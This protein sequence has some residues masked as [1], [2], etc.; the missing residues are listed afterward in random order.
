MLT[1]TYCTKLIAMIVMQRIPTNDQTKRKL[2]TRV[3]KHKKN[4]NKDAPKRSVI[5]EHMQQYNHNFN[6]DNPAI[7]NHKQN[8][9]KRLISE[10]I[11][12]KA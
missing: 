2:K 9:H 7:L 5:T 3:N 10:M 1:I 11:R 12:I 6:W 8:Y 4:I